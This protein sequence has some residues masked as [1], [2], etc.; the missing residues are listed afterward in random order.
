MREEGVREGWGGEGTDSNRSILL[1][2]GHLQFMSDGRGKD[3]IYYVII[4]R[5]HLSLIG[6]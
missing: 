1:M 5:D 3:L 2:C 6:C 4:M